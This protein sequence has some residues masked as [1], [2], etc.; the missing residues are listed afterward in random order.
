MHRSRR[1]GRCSR[2]SS[3]LMHH[4]EAD[5][6]TDT[7]AMERNIVY[8][9]PR[10]GMNVQHWLTDVSLCDSDQD[11]VSMPCPA[12]GSHHFVNSRTGRLLAQNEPSDRGSRSPRSSQHTT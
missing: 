11:Y 2:G 8:K 6:G 7:S 12:C 10:M 9:C 4:N 1:A 5:T 3:E